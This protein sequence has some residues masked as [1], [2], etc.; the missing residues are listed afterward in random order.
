M[1]VGRNTLIKSVTFKFL[2][3]IFLVFLAVFSTLFFF[4][5]K[6]IERNDKNNFIEKG[7]AAAQSLALSLSRTAELDIKNGIFID[8]KL[9]RGDQLEKL[10]FDDNLAV[11]KESEQVAEKRKQDPKYA[12]QKVTLHD[13]KEIPL[14]QYELKYISNSDKYTDLRWQSII[15][16]YMGDRNIV[17]ALPTKYS[18]DP[19]KSGY[20]GT[21]NS[22]Y[23]PVGEKSKDAW[24]DEGLL[25]QKYRANRIF[26]DSTGFN[27]AKYTLEEV[28]ASKNEQENNNGALV[29]QY[30][31]VIENTI[32]NMW[33]VS[34]PITINGKHWGSVRVSMSQEKAEMLIA[35]EK[36]ALIIKFAIIGFI[37]LIFLYILTYFVVGK[38]ITTLYKST[39]AIF[40]NGRIRLSSNLNVGGHDEIGQLNNQINHFLRSLQETVVSIQEVSSQIEGS[41]ND[42]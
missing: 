39:E 23:S 21:H 10:I 29:Q 36:Q 31:R 42:L 7:R 17:F 24:G 3:M 34:Y 18:K 40:S 38:R 6:D 27:A 14:W 41:S 30:P 20:I 2:S 4:S 25:S 35:K 16:S 32:V 12:E 37:V 5:G 9:Y 19:D 22:V 33:D 11:I 8:G 15:D 1:P 26:N 13:G 28:N